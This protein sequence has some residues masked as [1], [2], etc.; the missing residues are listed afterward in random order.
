MD[1][2]ARET[3]SR[4]AKEIERDR[5]MEREQVIDRERDNDTGRG[6]TD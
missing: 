2:L 3:R 6:K 5:D 1:M 4:I